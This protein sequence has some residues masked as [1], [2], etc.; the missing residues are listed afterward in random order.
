MNVF[1]SSGEDN[2]FLLNFMPS[3]YEINS[4]YFKVIHNPNKNC[5]SGTNVVLIWA[6]L[7][8]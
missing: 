8:D 6:F 1:I 4:F 3:I 7:V 5:A 2:P